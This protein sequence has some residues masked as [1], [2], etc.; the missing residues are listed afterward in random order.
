MVRL[1]LAVRSRPPSGG[2]SSFP[3][4]GNRFHSKGCLGALSVGLGSANNSGFSSFDTLELC[5]AD[6]IHLRGWSWQTEASLRET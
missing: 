6:W 5:S 4:G 1:E 2:G 3:K